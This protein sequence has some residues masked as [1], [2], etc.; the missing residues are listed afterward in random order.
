VR[1]MET[2]S[3]HVEG[4]MQILYHLPLTHIGC[5]DLVSKE[6]RPIEAD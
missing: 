1:G 5:R 6:P 2:S 4:I 3:E